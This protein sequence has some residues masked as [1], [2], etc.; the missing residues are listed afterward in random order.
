MG[1]RGSRGGLLR[2]PRRAGPGG[3]GPRAGGR[4]GTGAEAYTVLLLLKK[5]KDVITT[6]EGGEID[7]AFEYYWSDALSLPTLPPSS[8]SSSAP[9]SPLPARAAPQRDA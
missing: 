9:H 7:V 5:T 1:M 8:F 4:G 6:F 3:R 2:A